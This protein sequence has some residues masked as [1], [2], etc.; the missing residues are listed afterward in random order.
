MV[1]QAVVPHDLVTLED[2]RTSVLEMNDGIG[3][4]WAYHRLLQDLLSYRYMRAFEE[5]LV[6]IS[7]TLCQQKIMM[8]PPPLVFTGIYSA[9]SNFDKRQAI[10]DTWLKVLMQWGKAHG[11][12]RY[13]FFLGELAFSP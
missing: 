7:C 9:K 13:K 3:F 1:T 2:I 11:G 5:R 4:L 12:M 6:S 8:E 10:R